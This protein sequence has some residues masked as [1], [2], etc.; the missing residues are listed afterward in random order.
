[1]LLLLLFRPLLLLLL[2]LGLRLF[3][4]ADVARC[5]PAAIAARLFQNRYGSIEFVYMYTY[6]L[7]VFRSTE[8]DSLT[9]TIN[10]M[11][12]F[13]MGNKKEW[14]ALTVV[15]ILRTQPC[16]GCRL[17]YSVHCIVLASRMNDQFHVLTIASQIQW[18]EIVAVA[19]HKV[20]IML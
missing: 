19:S 12:E 3:G 9:T 20:Y 1:M 7:R 10:R 16:T 4:I 14:G 13:A 15:W 18:S 6:W 17:Y 2:L 5:A 11:R 8:A